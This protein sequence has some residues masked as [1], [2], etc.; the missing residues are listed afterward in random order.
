LVVDAFLVKG[1][2]PDGFEQYDGFRT[3]RYKR[4]T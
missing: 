1:Y 2:E 3:Y 4:W